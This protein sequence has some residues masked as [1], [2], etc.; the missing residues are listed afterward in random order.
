MATTPSARWLDTIPRAVSSTGNTRLRFSITPTSWVVTQVGILLDWGG[1]EHTT[2]VIDGTESAYGYVLPRGAGEYL[3]VIKGASVFERA[4]TLPA[5][6]TITADVIVQDPSDSSESGTATLTASTTIYA[7]PTVTITSPAEGATV[8]ALP[9]TI[10]WDVT[11]ATGISGQHIQFYGIDDYFPDPAAREYTLPSDLIENDTSYFVEIVAYNGV[12]LSSRDGVNFSTHWAPPAT[13]TARTGT[14][15]ADLS[16]SVT[17]FEGY[18]DGNEPATSSL[19]VTR[20]NPDGTRWVV[21]SGLRSGET[22]IDPL[23]PL[24]VEYSYAVTAVTEAG[25][26]SVATVTRTV[27]SAAWALNFGATAGEVMTLVGNPKASYSLDQGGKAYHFADGG[28]GNGLPVWYGTTD[29]DESGTL[30]FDTKGPQES[31][32]LREL[33]REYPVAWIRD[34]FGHRW[35]AHVQPKI[36]HGVGDLW[37]ASVT[38][39]AVRYREAW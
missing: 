16:V 17:V 38:W 23:P 18:I 27:E 32:R 9:L 36:S 2:V 20:I 19:M 4:T 7:P 35:R 13:P 1:G 37:A 39:D 31:D 5:A 24:G 11:D 8:S 26:T 3:M 10:T 29:R 34:P 33:C 14:N 28:A 12:G 6:V 15:H 25:T 21:A 22:C 30:S